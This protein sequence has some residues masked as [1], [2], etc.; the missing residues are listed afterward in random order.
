MV[1]SRNSKQDLKLDSGNPD[2]EVDADF[3]ADQNQTTITTKHPKV[4][5]V[6]TGL[7]LL[8]FASANGQL[9]IEY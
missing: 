4:T 9:V 8:R 7:V 1:L 6:Q 5:T 2:Q 3:K